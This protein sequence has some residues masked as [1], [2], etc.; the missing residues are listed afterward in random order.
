MSAR[1]LGDPFARRVVSAIAV[2][3][4]TAIAAGVI[5]SATVAGAELAGGEV[6]PAGDTI[7][8]VMDMFVP[9]ILVVFGLAAAVISATLTV[10][11]M[12]SKILP[13]WLAYTGWLAVVGALAAGVFLPFALTMLWL[14]A[15]AIHGLVR[16]PVADRPAAAPLAPLDPEPARI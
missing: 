11:A 16:P 9:L 8:A 12:R 5:I 1:L 7:G 6:L 15:V 14:L 2:L 4:A 13:S 10:A 3:G